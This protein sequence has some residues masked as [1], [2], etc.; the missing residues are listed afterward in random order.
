MAGRTRPGA[1]IGLAGAGAGTVAL[2]SG[3]ERNLLSLAG[4][5]LGDPGLLVLDEPGN[6]LDYAGL[7]WLEEM[8]ASFLGGVLLVSHNRR[9]AGPDGYPHPGVD[10]R[11]HP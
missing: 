2:L 11:P 3:G 5:L 1:G 4:A 7:E 9:L 8:L 10:R 6:H